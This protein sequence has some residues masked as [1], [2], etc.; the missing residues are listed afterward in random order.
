MYVCVVMYVYKM[1]GSAVILWILEF[2]VK[3]WF[4]SNTEHD[5]LTLESSTQNGS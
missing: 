5:L 3:V 2:R 1:A 4:L